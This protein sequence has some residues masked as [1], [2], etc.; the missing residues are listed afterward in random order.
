[1]KSVISGAKLTKQAAYC[2]LADFV[3]QRCGTKWDGKQAGIR[4]KSFLKLYKDTR[5]KYLSDCGKK[6]GLTSDE[7]KSGLSIEEKLEQE[8]LTGV[9]STTPTAPGKL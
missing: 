2:D 7:L 6:Y 4:Y 5:S 8:K 3:N 9:P 1:M